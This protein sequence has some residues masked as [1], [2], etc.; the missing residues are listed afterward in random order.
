MTST[1]LASRRTNR[2]SL[3]WTP[4][5]ASASHEKANSLAQGRVRPTSTSILRDGNDSGNDAAATLPRRLNI[6]FDQDTRAELTRRRA[7]AASTLSSSKSYDPRVMLGHSGLTAAVPPRTSNSEP[8]TS[9]SIAQRLRRAIINNDLA[10]ARRLAAH[11][12]ALAASRCRPPGHDDTAG[13]DESDVEADYHTSYQAHHEDVKFGRATRRGWKRQRELLASENCI[14]CPGS[15]GKYACA[16][17][18]CATSACSSMPPFSIRNLSPC[19]IAPPSHERSRF[20]DG[21]GTHPSTSLCLPQPPPP[22]SI[23]AEMQGHRTSLELAIVYDCSIQLVEWLLENGHEE[24][25][26]T[27]SNSGHLNDHEWDWVVPTK[28]DQGRTMPHLAALHNRADIVA[29]YCS[30][31]HFLLSVPRIARMVRQER[32]EPWERRGPYEGP[33]DSV[34]GG[35]PDLG[36]KDDE[37]VTLKGTDT[38]PPTRRPSHIPT[39]SIERS[40]EDL[41]LVDHRRAQGHR[42]AHSP[43]D[44]QDL[45]AALLDAAPV[46]S[47]SSGAWSS[48]DQGRTALHGAAMRGYDSVVLTLLDLGADPR[49]QDVLGNTALHYA[50]SF[51]HVSTLQLLIEAEKVDGHPTHKVSGRRLGAHDQS[52]A[53]ASFLHRVPSTDSTNGRGARLRSTDSSHLDGPPSPTTPTTS[54]SIFSIKNDAGFSAADYA[55]TQ[56]D[57][58]ALEALGRRWFAESREVARQFK[59]REQQDLL[60]LQ[61]RRLGDTS[62]DS[63]A[64]RMSLDRGFDVGSGYSSSDF[65][66]QGVPNDRPSNSP[67]ATP[68]LTLP[69]S[70]STASAASTPPSGGSTPTPRSTPPPQRPSSAGEGIRDQIASHIPIP[71]AGR[72]KGGNGHVAAAKARAQRAAAA[73]NQDGNGTTAS[74]SRDASKNDISP[75][76]QSGDPT[77]TNGTSSSS[78]GHR[79]PMSDVPVSP[80]AAGL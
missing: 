61:E 71:L 5:A 3:Q 18:A 46:F 2:N 73:K 30:H 64:T 79:S 21:R 43:D 22:Y 65:A 59:R 58:A 17:G 33:R 42:A 54:H 13:G 60:S 34:D 8:S 16:N 12:S 77:A 49:R 67:A 66:P 10:A 38:E 36:T 76:S 39:P 28:D 56:K 55:F 27:T 20:T 14:T 29:L 63:D 24:H 80:R 44:A 70:T 74:R 57:R 7:T 23:E 19:A 35:S 4:S 48:R 51:G 53:R 41:S 31:M 25:D 78:N 69:A 1:S 15:S 6:H 40:I 37:L 26:A 47:S 62:K 32:A 52:K 75:R 68:S 50:S 72:F 11:A 9:T 45:I